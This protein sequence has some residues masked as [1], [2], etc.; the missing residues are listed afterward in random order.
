VWLKGVFKLAVF[1]SFD[2]GV[3]S[4]MYLLLLLLLLLLLYPALGVPSGDTGVAGMKFPV[5]R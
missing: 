4:A 1:R 5:P 2:F 3:F